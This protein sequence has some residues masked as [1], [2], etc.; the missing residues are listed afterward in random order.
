[1]TTADCLSSAPLK[2]AGMSFRRSHGRRPCSSPATYCCVLHF[3]SATTRRR[4]LFQPARVKLTTKT[5]SS[6]ELGIQRLFVLSVETD[7]RSLVN[8]SRA[9]SPDWFVSIKPTPTNKCAQVCAH[10]SM[11][12]SK[13][14]RHQ[15]GVGHT[16]Q[17]PM[18]EDTTPRNPKMPCGVSPVMLRKWSA[19]GKS[20]NN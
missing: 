3:S 20:E 19:I 16:C 8:K 9:R 10:A 12:A 13:G 1:M 6:S 15:A 2:F 17:Q 11:N 4:I 14:W 5:Q 18:S 7:K